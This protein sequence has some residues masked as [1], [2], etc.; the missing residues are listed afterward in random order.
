M[1]PWRYD[2][3][4]DDVQR[5]ARDGAVCLRSVLSAETVGVMQCAVEH[6]LNSLS[7]DSD[8]YAKPGEK[9]FAQDMFMHRRSDTVGSAFRALV[10]DSPL[11]LVAAR[12]MR[13]LTARFFYDQMFV[14]EPGAVAPTP[15][16]QDQPYW[17]LQGQ[18]VCGIWCPLD[19][20]DLDSGGVQYVRGSH[21][22]GT[23]YRPRHFGG[24]LAYPGARG[25]P[26]PDIEAT[27]AREDLLSWA[28]NPGDCIVFHGMVI[29]GAGGNHTLNRRRRAVSMRWVGD[30]VTY[31][32]RPGTYPFDVAGLVAGQPLDDK[33]YPVVWRERDQRIQP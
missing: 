21:A 4:E 18:Q 6:A 24:E 7:K 30:D 23:W 31:D 17:P 16:H 5:Y 10:H 2:V 22:T 25:E 1:T 13:S 15:W 3:Q 27:V 29:H 33:R 8:D 11:A 26:M 12:L 19:V 14:K 28:M 9:R 32:D 20:V